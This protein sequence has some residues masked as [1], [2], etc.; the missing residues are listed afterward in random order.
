[1][2]P[3][4]PIP[5]SDDSVIFELRDG[6]V[7]N[8]CSFAVSDFQQFPAFLTANSLE[9]FFRRHKFEQYFLSTIHALKFYLLQ[10]C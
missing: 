3:T 8:T 9:M 4:R 2:A 5:F 10:A 6:R 1:V 7:R